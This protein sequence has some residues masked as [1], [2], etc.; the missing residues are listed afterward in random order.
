M[1]RIVLG[2]VAAAA[3]AAAIPA[4]A[5]SFSVEAFGG[6]QNLRVATSSVT[7]AAK[8]NEGTGIFGGQVLAGLGPL[9][10]GV[11]VDKTTGSSRPLPSSTTQITATNNPVTGS[12]LAGFLVPMSV[13]RLE[14]LGEVG[15]R[16]GSFGDVFKSGAETIVGVRPGVSFRIPATPFI[17]GANGIVRWPTSNGDF[18]SPDYGIVGR[19]GLGMF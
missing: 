14:V 6:W 15:R 5:Q 7:N 16:A 18:G 12:I 2:A 8:G 9:G 19:V 1:N 17:I 4:R 11:L 13:V 3:L 10:V